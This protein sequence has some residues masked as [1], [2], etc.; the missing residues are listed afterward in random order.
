[1]SG[2]VVVGNLSRDI[3]AGGP[4]QVGGA[5]YWCARAL[6]LL[7][8][9][10][11]VVAGCALAD[12]PLLV[13]PLEA[14]GV[15]VTVVPTRATPGFSFDYDGD[16]R[17]MTVDAVAEPWTERELAAVP[18]EAEAVHVG[19]LFQGEFPGNTLA[20]LAREDRLVSLDGQGLV[21]AR[22]VGPLRLDPGESLL[23]SLEGVTILKLA[24]E[25]AE[26][27]LGGVTREQ[28]ARLDVPEVVVT[29]GA[30]GALVWANGRL[31][32]VTP[33][34]VVEREPTGAGDTFAVGYLAARADGA[35][36]VA[37][38]E[39]GAALVVAVLDPAERD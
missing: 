23:Q 24:V 37:A 33:P 17:R 36:P 6:A 31:E 12:T 26:A 35:D 38:A 10:S 28:L 7:E 18:D 19:A 1:V 13:P 20:A 11:V 34:R 15:P 9:P 5:P 22:L 8:R 3:V 27:L 21:R 2:L 32:H 16:T 39:A 4:P 25:E 29:F 14:L 30:R